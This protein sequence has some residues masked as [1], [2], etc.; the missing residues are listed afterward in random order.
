MRINWGTGIVLSFVAFISFILFFVVRMNMDSK[1]N[2]DL[3]TEDYYKDALNHQTE[4]D[5]EINAN[6]HEKI[7]LEKTTEGLLLRFPLTIDFKKAQGK[8]SLYRPSNKQLD[9]DLPV[10]LSNTNLLI[11][12]KRLLDGRW[13]IKIT[14]TYEGEDYLQKESI[15]Y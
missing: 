13:D 5:A 12:D 1:A 6:K 8:V 10:S 7:T 3:V 15:T 11:P 9:F 2:H 4:L 14:W